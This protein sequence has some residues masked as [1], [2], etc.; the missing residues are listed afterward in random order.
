MYSDEYSR[1][2][3]KAVTNPNF[4]PEDIWK[5]ESREAYRLKQGST[6][7]TALPDFISSTNSLKMKPDYII[8]QPIYSDEY[9]NR[10]SNAALF[11]DVINSALERLSYF[12]LGT[13]DEIRA[14]LYPESL[15]PKMR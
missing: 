15:R 10:L 5:A 9:L 3:T 8:L 4:E 12:T 14:V 6:A 7:T 11:D 1:I 2:N 13:S